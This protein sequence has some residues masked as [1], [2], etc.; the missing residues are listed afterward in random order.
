M[1]GRLKLLDTKVS[2]KIIAFPFASLVIIAYMVLNFYTGYVFKEY[3]VK[4]SG[5]NHSA[6]IKKE[7]KKN[8]H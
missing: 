1:Y 4:K 7:V 6:M 3:G 2:L 5:H 8:E